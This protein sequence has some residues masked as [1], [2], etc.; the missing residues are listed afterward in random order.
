VKEVTISEFKVK[1]LALLAQLQKTKSP[2][3]VTRFGKPIAEAVPL[4]PA[5]APHGIGS[6]KGRIEIL[7]DIVSPATN[8]TWGVGERGRRAPHC[9]SRYL[10]FPGLTAPG[11]S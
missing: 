10:D 5:S 8:R 3:R 9:T 7:G 11:V 1:C 4:S 6:M 2:M